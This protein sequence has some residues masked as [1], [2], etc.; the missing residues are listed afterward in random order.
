MLYTMIIWK[1]VASAQNAHD[2]GI[3]KTVD[4]QNLTMD[5]RVDTF[6]MLLPKTSEVDLRSLTVI[7]KTEVTA[8]HFVHGTYCV[9]VKA[10]LSV[11]QSYM[12]WSLPIF[13]SLPFII[14]QFSRF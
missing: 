13:R 12:K 14:S 11:S 3:R 10:L 1:A 2:A 8:N 6:E 7:S 4:L 9:S 5:L